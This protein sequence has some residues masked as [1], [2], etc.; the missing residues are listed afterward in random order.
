MQY[1]KSPL[2]IAR[3]GYPFIF[4]PLL[5]AGILYGVFCWVC[6]PSLLVAF[7]LFSAYF[8]YRRAEVRALPHRAGARGQVHRADRST[9]P[10]SYAGGV[11]PHRCPSDHSSTSSSW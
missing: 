5:L 8:S 1:K 2:P 6:M 9:A 11:A 7:G 4:G 3:E 10:D